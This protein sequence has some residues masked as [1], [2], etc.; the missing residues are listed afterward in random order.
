MSGQSAH[1][2]LLANPT[3][4]ERVLAYWKAAD[5]A[6]VADV[7]GVAVGIVAAVDT[8]GRP[9][10]AAVDTA[11][12]VQSGEAGMSA[13]HLML[14]AQ[15]SACSG[16]PSPASSSSAYQSSKYWGCR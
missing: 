2:N 15:S 12:A 5:T 16:L 10:E 3:V 9:A 4:R 14:L 8:V 13:R 6:D 11:A 7:A 1:S